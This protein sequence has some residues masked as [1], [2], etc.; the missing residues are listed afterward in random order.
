MCA[1]VRALAAG[2]FHVALDDVKKSAL[3]ALRHRMIL[4]F[5]GEAAGTG[6]DRLIEDIMTELERS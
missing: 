2:R 5:E 4:N 1:K 3:P 6:T